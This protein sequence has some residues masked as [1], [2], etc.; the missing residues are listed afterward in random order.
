MGLNWLWLERKLERR[1]QKQMTLGEVLCFV[2][3]LLST[4]K[5]R[6]VFS[7][8]ASSQPPSGSSQHPDAHG[9]LSLFLLLARARTKGRIHYLFLCLD[10]SL[11]R[12]S[13]LNPK[14]SFR[15]QA[16]T[17]FIPRE[18]KR[19]RGMTKD[20]DKGSFPTLG[21][22]GEPQARVRFFL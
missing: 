20:C 11:G 4:A 6:V 17:V 12:A 13:S 18:R 7:P 14:T 8:L 16:V 15:R 1:I 9:I 21:F 3:I 10:S 5:G 22:N 2:W 19:I